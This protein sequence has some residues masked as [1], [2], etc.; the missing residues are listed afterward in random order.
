MLLSGFDNNRFSK[1]TDLLIA[2]KGRTLSAEENLVLKEWMQENKN[3][4]DL[5]ES[6]NDKA[7]FL[8]RI[9]ELS[10]F[11]S[12]KAF[13]RFLKETQIQ[14]HYNFK[15]I[16]RIA[17]VIGPLVFGI[18][19]LLHE[20]VLI[21]DN[22]SDSLTKD[23]ISGSVIRIEPGY[24]K[25]ILKL[26]DGSSINL[27]EEERNIATEMGVNIKSNKKEVVYQSAK[28][29]IVTKKI[30]YNSIYIPRG[31]EFHLTLSDGTKVWLNSET[32]IKYPVV[33][34]DANREIQLRGEAYFEVSENKDKP[35]IIHTPEIDIQVTGTEFNVRTYEE[36]K[37]SIATLIDGEVSIIQKKSKEVVKLK[38]GYQ[39]V[40][41]GLDTKVKKVNTDQYIAWKNGRIYFENNPLEEILVDL[42]R[43]YDVEIDYKD[44]KLKKLRFSIDIARYSEFNKVFELVEL[45]K[46]VKFK[47]EKNH[48]TVLAEI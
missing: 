44:D 30:E 40:I 19:F 9:E 26:S 15:K 8:S 7:I 1:I 41:K 28:E 22:I 32:S 37:M 36:E 45:T 5:Y 48:V 18:Y 10:N 25:A 39:A 12:D 14:N 11:D 46:K 24:S 42:A 47:I 23:N 31:G 20:K 13:N 16:L 43:W 3:N 35:F 38:P 2:E 29:Q 33:F 6:L 34:T 4:K 21:K 17:A 27:E